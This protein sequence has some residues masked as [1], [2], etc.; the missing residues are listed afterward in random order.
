MRKRGFD[1]EVGQYHPFKRGLGQ[2]CVLSLDH[3]SLEIENTGSLKDISMFVNKGENSTM[4]DN[5]LIKHRLQ[6][7]TMIYITFS[8]CFYIYCLLYEASLTIKL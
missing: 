1:N 6:T 4:L 7:L 2:G 8:S 5:K 3:F